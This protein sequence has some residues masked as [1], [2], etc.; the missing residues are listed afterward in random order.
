MRRGTFRIRC[1]QFVGLHHIFVLPPGVPNAAC[2]GSAKLASCFPQ[3]K[4]SGFFKQRSLRLRTTP[5]RKVICYATSLPPSS[6]GARTP[7]SRP[8][9]LRLL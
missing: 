8:H 3:R 9:P 4:H 1:Q 2:I 5:P 6:H 7:Q